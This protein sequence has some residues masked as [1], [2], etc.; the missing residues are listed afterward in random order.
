MRRFALFLVSFITWI[1]L[2][3]PYHPERGEWDWESVYIGL[4]S[5]FLVSVLFIGIFT[6]SPRKFF[7]PRRWFW[8][9]VYIP[10]FVYYMI[11]A[12][13]QVV[14]LALHP[15]MPISPGI[16]RVRTGLKSDSGITA[17]AN[18]ITLTPGTFTLDLDRDKG[19]L[20]VHWLKVKTVDEEEA[21][22]EIPGR[23]EKFL[24]RIFE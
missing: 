5:A 13:L 6:R 21:T 8:V 7:D 2:V 12:N 19:V 3:F 14:Y 11:R 1:L 15:K 4:A 17:L 10:V 20:Y 16:V 18:S 9:L 22:K 24:R 23:F